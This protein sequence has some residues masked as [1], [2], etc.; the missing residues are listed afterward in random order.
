MKVSIEELLKRE[1]SK[2]KV[3]CIIALDAERLNNIKKDPTY[4]NESETPEEKIII[5]SMKR[6]IEGKVIY[7][8]MEDEESAKK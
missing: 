5:Q 4:I 7:G 1:K 6:F 3:C 2:Y 8:Y